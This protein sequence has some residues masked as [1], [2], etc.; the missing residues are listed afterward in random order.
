LA[1][2]EALSSV[3]L[4][5]HYR[6][7]VSL[8]GGGEDNVAWFF[9]HCDDYDAGFREAVAWV[10][11]HAEPTAELSTEI[12]LPA[13][14]YAERFGR[15]DLVHTLMRRGQACVGGRPCYALVQRGRLYFKN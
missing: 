6:L 3:E 14:L 15:S 4:A 13:Q 7:Y 2:P 11:A 12:E 8:L 5:P 9:P 1:V 10:A